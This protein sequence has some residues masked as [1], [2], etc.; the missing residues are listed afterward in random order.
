[1]KNTP[2]MIERTFKASASKVWEAIT[3]K[4]KMKEWYFDLKEFNP[5]AGFEFRFYGGPP[6]KQY[7]HICEITEVIPMRKLVHGWRYD[8]YEG[9][10]FVTFELFEEGKSTRLKLTHAELETFPAN[11][12][13]FSRKNFE[14]GW[15]EIIGTSLK[16]FLGQMK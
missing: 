3:H 6:E 11:N 9:N 14:G 4:D 16:N 8:G 12:P 5:V 2:L 7:L 1:M 15:N 10:S 13:D